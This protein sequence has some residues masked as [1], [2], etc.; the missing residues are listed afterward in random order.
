M[1]KRLGIKGVLIAVLLLGA[2]GAFAQPQ[3]RALL[4]G[5]ND[6]QSPLI[7]DLKGCENDSKAIR[8]TLI[9]SFGFR[10][11]NIRTLLT[12]E[13]TRDRILKEFREFLIAGTKPGDWVLFAF[14]GHG[15]QAKDMNGDEDDGLDEILLTYDSDVNQWGSWIS[16]DE[17]GELLDA[18]AGRTVLVL[19]DCCHSGTATRT[20]SPGMRGDRQNSTDCIP[21]GVDNFRPVPPPGLVAQTA[22]TRSAGW[23]GMQ[24]S[25]VNQVVIT[26][27][28][29]H[30]KAMDSKF[31][32]PDGRM[33]S[34]GAFTH[35]LLDGLMGPADMDSNG[36]ITFQE[37]HGYAAK[38]LRSSGFKQEPY[39][40]ASR[41]LENLE[42]FGRQTTPAGTVQALDTQPPV[43]RLLGAP[44]VSVECG[45][46]YTDAGATASD[47]RDGDLTTSI[48]VN[49][50]VNS[51]AAG[52]YEVSYDVKDAAGNAAKTVQRKVRVLDSAPPS[53]R[54]IGP[55][56][57]E[58]ACGTAYVDPGAQAADACEGDISGRI[59]VSGMVD[60]AQ[61]GVYTLQYQARD[62]AGNAAAPLTRSV[63]VVDKTPP[64]ITLIGAPAISIVQG[65]SYEDAGA[66][67]HDVCDGDI[68]AR[69]QIRST[70]NTANPGSYSVRYEVSD[71]AGNKAHAERKVTVLKAPDDP[72]AAAAV[73]A[74]EAAKEKE[75]AE[76]E[77]LEQARLKEERRKQ[78]Q[79][80]KERI[81]AAQEA[82]L[83]AGQAALAAQE[84]A[85]ETSAAPVAAVA[86]SAPAP[87]QQ[88]VVLPLGLLGKVAEGSIFEFFD[89]AVPG[90]EAACK[91]RIESV[92]EDTATGAVIE[93]VYQAHYVAQCTFTPPNTRN[94]RVS[95][96]G[97]GALFNAIVNAVDFLPQLDRVNEEEAERRVYVD[98][99]G[100]VRVLNMWGDLNRSWPAGLAVNEV[101]EDVATYLALNYFVRQLSE[102]RNPNNSF[103]V[104]VSS[105]PE[106]Q[107]AVRDG[108]VLQYEISCD[109]AARIIVFCMDPTGDVT[110]LFPYG[111]A[112]DNRV[113][114][115]Q[116]LR[117][118]PDDSDYEI[119]AQ[120]P[121]GEMTIKVF[122]F[123]DSAEVN[124]PVRA[125]GVYSGKKELA[126]ITDKLLRMFYDP[127][128]QVRWAEVSLVQ[129]TKGRQ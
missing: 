106:G 9:A 35:F 76:R 100:S 49:N 116:K 53:M 74:A 41:G 55:E 79:L 4:V 108:D 125:A 124:I 3:K 103:Q 69:I 59:V 31:P 128:K 104:R 57:D 45:T 40:E 67:A 115:G 73:Q 47:D 38:M 50:R 114:A 61:P 48:T 60:T 21:R 7:N 8:Q 34:F 25:N 77:R 82:A 16:D 29:A 52:T 63:Q 32:G 89:P 90:S 6:Y 92:T 111:D 98:A 68:S 113:R 105:V 97:S 65:E 37:L 51:N 39:F 15:A 121:L 83:A 14:S 129:E 85:V 81:Q 30:Q 62:S 36:T 78:E 86:D 13:A 101:R 91:V 17:M 11:D 112:Q 1:Y 22:R 46:A 84:Q 80:E 26:G 10:P 87:A 24:Q 94:L 127:K 96:S 56:T 66:T 27:A 88:E 107:F 23:R 120:E 18:L 72:Q 20:V 123:A 44:E 64:A 71:E 75:K 110:V 54:L 99:D 5:I 93:G 102:I 43:I 42:F 28:Q 109:E 58:I 70:V 95:I 117:I 122:A 119:R 2:A 126:E 19:L 12:Q 33:L 118:Y